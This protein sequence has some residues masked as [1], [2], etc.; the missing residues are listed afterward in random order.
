MDIERSSRLAGF[1]VVDVC[2]PAE[3]DERSRVSQRLPN[4]NASHTYTLRDK[5]LYRVASPTV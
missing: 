3:L 1:T 2:D 5:A 4:Q